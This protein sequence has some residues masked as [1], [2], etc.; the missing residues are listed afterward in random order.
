MFNKPCSLQND[1]HYDKLIYGRGLRIGIDTI[2]SVLK[3]SL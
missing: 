2:I 3:L 1:N